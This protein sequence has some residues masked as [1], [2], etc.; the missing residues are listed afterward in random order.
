M[1]NINT[2]KKH[3]PIV[4]VV[5]IYSGSPIQLDGTFEFVLSVTR[6]KGV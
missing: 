5:Y 3:I 4:L 6:R 1:Y 2:L